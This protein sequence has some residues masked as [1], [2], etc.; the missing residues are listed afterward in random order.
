MPRPPRRPGTA[1]DRP[2]AICPTLSASTCSPL[3]P[4]HP[5]RWSQG[6]VDDP[7]GRARFFGQFETRP[8]KSPA[9]GRA[10]CIDP[11]GVPC[12][13]SGSRPGRASTG[14]KGLLPQGGRGRGDQPAASPWRVSSHPCQG[15]RRPVG[16]QITAGH[17]ATKLP[18]RRWR[19]DGRFRRTPQIRLAGGKRISRRPWTKAKPAKAAIQP[20]PARG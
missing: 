5:K 6:V 1:G 10:R 15:R 18:D 14:P 17:F 2:V 7:S 20:S 11:L 4:C 13:P 16:R 8:R 12:T 19:M 9:A 3:E